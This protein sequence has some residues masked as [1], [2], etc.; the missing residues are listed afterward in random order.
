[1]MKYTREHGDRTTSIIDMTE[2]DTSTDLVI[3]LTRPLGVDENPSD[4]PKCASVE[5]VDGVLITR[6]GIKLETLAA[7]GMVVQ[8]I[9]DAKQESKA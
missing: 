5:A 6:I 7:L 8:D 3:E 2:C 1:M 4:P 9:I